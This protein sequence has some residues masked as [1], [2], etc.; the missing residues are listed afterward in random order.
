MK[1][2]YFSNCFCRTIV[3]LSILMAEEKSHNDE[4]PPLKKVR[5]DT[6]IYIYNKKGKILRINKIPDGNEECSYSWNKYKS[7]V[8]KIIIDDKITHIPE[9]A[10]KNCYHL[11]EINVPTQSTVAQNAFTNCFSLDIFKAINEIFGQ[12]SINDM[13]IQHLIES[14][15]YC[16]KY[17]EEWDKNDIYH[18]FGVLSPYLKQIYDIKKLKGN[19]VQLFSRFISLIM[20]LSYRVKSSDIKLKFNSIYTEINK[21][22]IN[23]NAV[24]PSSIY[25]IIF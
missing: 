9:K 13:N 12:I 2:T 10:F 25:F 3:D 16:L 17:L 14:I 6:E 11:L 18:D 15:L 1:Q 21:D 24:I 5:Y 22:S 7:E 4:G 19:F 8:K 20:P 23:E